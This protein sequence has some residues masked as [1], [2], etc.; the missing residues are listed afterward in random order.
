MSA[1][2]SSHIVMVRPAAF[3]YNVETAENN[4]FQNKPVSGKE[5]IIQRAINEFD[6]LVQILRA[7]GIVVEVIQDTS[8]P[9]K[10]DAIFPNNW[11]SL[12]DNGLVV[13]YPIFSPLRRPERRV[14][15][16][17]HLARHYKVK[18]HLAMEYFE[19]QGLFLEGTGSMVLDRVNKVAYACLSPRTD[20]G[21]LEVW[22]EKMGYTPFTFIAMY[23]QQEV[24]H[25]NVMMAIGEGVCV[26]SLDIVNQSERNALRNNLA[27]GG[28]EVVELS[29]EQIGSFAGN[30]LAVRNQDGEQLMVM[31]AA[32]RQILDKEQVAAI[33][34]YARIISGD[35]RTIESVGGGSVRCMIAENFLPH[36]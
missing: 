17:Q 15:I 31:S 18:E 10:P 19:S 20:R 26:V 22:C 34:K 3:G 23:D 32:A 25:T 33:E 28:R 24:Y 29:R 36:I 11:L 21:V 6:N 5:T 8:D 12:H 14:E 27:A 9:A 30:M 35:I 7:E 1:Q 2:T 4:T 13:T 16:I